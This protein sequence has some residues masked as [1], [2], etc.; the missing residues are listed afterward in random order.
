MG[1]LMRETELYNAYRFLDRFQITNAQ[2]DWLINMNDKEC[3]SFDCI[4]GKIREKMNDP[5]FLENRAKD[6]LG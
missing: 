3:D 2:Y 4:I 1:L 6:V 5:E